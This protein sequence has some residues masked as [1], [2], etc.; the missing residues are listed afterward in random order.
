MLTTAEKQRVVRGI[1][2]IL[3]G[4]DK[5]FAYFGNSPKECLKSFWSLVLLL[6]TAIISAYVTYNSYQVPIT[7]IE[8]IYILSMFFFIQATI[9]PLIIFKT[10]IAINAKNRIYNYISAHNWFCGFIGLFELC[11]QS[12]QFIMG[13]SANTFA[14]ITLVVGSIYFI[15]CLGYILNKSLQIRISQSIFLL[16][17]YMLILFVIGNFKLQ[18]I[19]IDLM[20]QIE[21]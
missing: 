19:G 7:K 11:I 1:L 6:P 14:A 16:V 15:Y 17:F 9:W 8:Y 12:V 20:Q 10:S 18:M 2:G 5:A 21:S 3:K 4:D 13:E